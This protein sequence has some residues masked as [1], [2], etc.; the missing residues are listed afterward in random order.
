MRSSNPLSIILENHKLFGLIF[1]DWLHNLKV[2]LASERILYIL[3]QSS[4]GPLPLD[5]MQEEQDTLK[6]L[7][8]NDLQS[9][10]IMWASMSNEIHR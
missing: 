8:D 4:P 1:I 7:K 5:A 10:C 2:I 9:R 3:E 6:K